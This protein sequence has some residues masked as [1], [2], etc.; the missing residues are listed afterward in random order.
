MCAHVRA[1]TCV[2]ECVQCVASHAY[3]DVIVYVCVCVCVC[4]NVWLCSLLLPY[5]YL[6]VNEDVCLCAFDCFFVCLVCVC[7]RS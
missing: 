4:E 1:C 2:Y 5:V 7:L 6:C 3:N